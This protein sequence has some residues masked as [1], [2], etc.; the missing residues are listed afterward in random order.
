MTR[1]LTCLICLGFLCTLSAPVYAAPLRQEDDTA[2]AAV[3]APEVADGAVVAAGLAA[4]AG[5]ALVQPADGGA[6]TGVS[7]PPLGLPVFAWQP[8]PG[9]DRYNIQISASA[10]FGSP[11][12]DVTTYATSYTPQVAFAD[13]TYY[14]A[15]ARPGQLSMGAGFRDP[16]LQQRLVRRRRALSA[17]A[18]PG[19]RQQPAL[20]C[21]RT[22]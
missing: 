15:R 20:L 11:V 7:A 6:F 13:G 9:A 5:P 18:Q 2:A 17:P 1:L 16:L 8:V 4:I 19:Q 14:S 3:S 12:V 21:A 10:G 22:L